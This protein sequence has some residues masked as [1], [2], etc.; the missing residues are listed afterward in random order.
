MKA[1]T[2]TRNR[3]ISQRKAS[4]AKGFVSFGLDNLFP[5][6]LLEAIKDSPTA[7]ACIGVKARFIEGNGF[8]NPDL[9]RMVVHRSGLRLDELLRRVSQN[10]APFEV[11]SLHVGYNGLGQITDIRPVGTEII[12]LGE[13]DDLGYT[14][15][16]GIFPFIASQLT[17][18]KKNEHA[19]INLFN[20]NPDVVQ[21]QI[22]LAGGISKY[23][24]QLIYETFWMPGDET[25]HS[26]SYLACIK[27]IETE[28]ELSTYD[29]KTVTNGFNISGIFAYLGRKRQQ[30][31]PLNES[32]PYEPQDEETDEITNQIIQHQGA[33][34]AASIMTISAENKEELELMKFFDTTGAQ[35]SDRYNST[36]NRV[37]ERIIRSMQV[38]AILANIQQGSSVFPDDKALQVA[39]QY[40]Q[41]HVNPYQ[42][43]IVEVL[44]NVF[45]HWHK[46]FPFNDF[47]IENL[48]Y[49][50]SNGGVVNAQ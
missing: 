38:P 18:N 5:Q 3:K 15:Q 44:T 17:P 19:R 46:P 37:S 41:A 47:T 13:P 42:R 23:P 30:R 25:Y 7:Q 26:P 22:E 4:A 2:P 10:F 45:T 36:N 32:D 28:A 29:Y 35:L 12:R 33:E 11:I 39:T 6:N 16:A 40:M 50:Q 1:K 24:G 31:A 34:N 9:A 48:N 43:K 20:P 21:E 27:D 14:F 8:L 49:F